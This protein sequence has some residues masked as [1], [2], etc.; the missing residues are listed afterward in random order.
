M[1]LKYWCLEGAVGAPGGDGGS[2]AARSG[3]VRHRLLRPSAVPE[4]RRPWS[5]G[6][7]VPGVARRAGALAVGLRRRFSAVPGSGGAGGPAPRRASPVAGSCG[8]AQRPVRSCDGEPR[9]GCSCVGS[10]R[11]PQLPVIAPATAVRPSCRVPPRCSKDVS[12]RHELRGGSG[13]WC[14][15]VG[16]GVGVG[17]VRVRSRAPPKRGPAP[18]VRADQCSS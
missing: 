8:G 9:S 15:T 18:V 3:S 2:S 7:F 10:C 17:V 4:V 12:P 5:G 16:V 11:G 13:A 6:R 14:A 1:I